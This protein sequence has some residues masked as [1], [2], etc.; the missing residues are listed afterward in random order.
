MTKTFRRLWRSMSCDKATREYDSM[1]EQVRAM[2]CR[3]R[4]RRA[5]CFDEE[6]DDALIAT[7]RRG[8]EQARFRSCKSSESTGP[9]TLHREGEA[10]LMGGSTELH[11]PADACGARRS[12][13]C[14]HLH[15][16][17]NHQD[18]PNSPLPANLMKILPL[19]PAIRRR[20]GL[21]E[22]HSRPDSP[23]SG[24][25]SPG[26]STVIQAL[27]GRGQTPPASRGDEDIAGTHV[28]WDEEVVVQMFRRTSPRRNRRRAQLVPPCMVFR[29][30]FGAGDFGSPIP[31]RPGGASDSS[32]SPSAPYPTYFG[33]SP[34]E[35]QQ[36]FRHTVI[37]RRN[38]GS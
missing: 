22:N 18:G 8:L 16:A 17:P 28:A 11:L 34:T 15:Q 6:E 7:L 29:P 3:P 4:L 14:E 12:Y 23:C 19:D 37:R 2:E 13:A 33:S 20:L 10:T 5:S 38:S 36:R 31:Q 30:G 26:P 21:D 9:D 35:P 1:L 24:D 25:S 27:S 32:Q